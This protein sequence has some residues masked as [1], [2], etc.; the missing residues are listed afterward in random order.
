M[1]LK[2]H[3]LKGEMPSGLRSSLNG[4]AAQADASA[5]FGAFKRALTWV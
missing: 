5:I 1:A 4:I 3:S 2:E